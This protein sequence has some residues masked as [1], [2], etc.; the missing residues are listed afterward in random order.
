MRVPCV[1]KAGRSCYDHGGDIAG[2]QRL[3]ANVDAEALQHRGERLLGKRNIVEGVA[4][5]VETNH[6]S[7][8]DELVLPNALD[9]GEV[10]DVRSP[11]R[12]ARR[13]RSIARPAMRLATSSSSL[14]PN[15]TLN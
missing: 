10:L 12:S 3:A 13:T 2:T 5:T 7:I 6:Q 4:G 11:P 9:I 15:V 14:L 8:T 1:E